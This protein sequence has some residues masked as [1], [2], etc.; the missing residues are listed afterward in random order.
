MR[1]IV[2]VD[3]SPG[4]VA[5]LLCRGVKSPP[6]VSCPLRMSGRSVPYYHRPTTSMSY[7]HLMPGIRCVWHVTY[8][9]NA[10]PA[11]HAW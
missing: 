11:P 5:A 7:T 10:L 1:V 2:Q 9:F 3:G 6:T 4:S 8:V